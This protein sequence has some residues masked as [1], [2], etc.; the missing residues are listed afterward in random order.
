LGVFLAGLG[1]GWVLNLCITRMPYEK[2]LIWPGPRC[3]S[4][5]QPLRWYDQVPVVSYLLLRGRCRTCQAAIARR[6]LWVELSTG[7]AF[8]GLFGVAVRPNRLALPLLRAGNRSPV[9]LAAVIVFAH[10]ATLLSFLLAATV[11][12]LMDMEIPMPLTM[13]GT[14]VGLVL[15][16]LLPW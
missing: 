6:Y 7:L 10:H 3:S 9:P 13:T 5:L 1:V 4:C 14:V 16:T 8:V 15:A 11:C 2:S 12:D